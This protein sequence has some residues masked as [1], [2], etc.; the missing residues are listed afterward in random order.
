M[1]RPKNPTEKPERKKRDPSSKTRGGKPEY[2]RSSPG[3]RSPG[4]EKQQE[5]IVNEDE[6]SK[7]VNKR[8]ENAQTAS[9]SPAETERPPSVAQENEIERTEAGYDNSEVN[10]RPP[11][12][13]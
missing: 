3:R 2:E 10:P 4:V 6:Q 5:R 12:V 8:E 1:N 13:N 7:A 9:A 11:K